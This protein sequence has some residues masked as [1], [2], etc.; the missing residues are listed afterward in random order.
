M[1][2]GEPNLSIDQGVANHDGLADFGC[3]IFVDL[4][5]YADPLGPQMTYI[6]ATAIA[7]SLYVYV[8]ADR[9]RSL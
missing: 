5:G 2:L 4:L 8:K 6:M 9:L 1:I 3:F 7:L